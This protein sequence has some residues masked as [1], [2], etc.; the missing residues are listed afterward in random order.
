MRYLPFKPLI[1][2][3][4]L[5]WDEDNN[6]PE[7]QMNSG[8]NVYLDEN[9]TELTVEA[10]VP[11]LDPKNLKVTYHDGMLHIYGSATQK[12]EERKKGKIIKKWEMASSVDYVTSLPRPIDT[13]SIDAKVKN[14]VMIIK[15]KIAEEA[16]P[17]E[18]EVKVG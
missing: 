7:M 16:K 6:W 4:P 11:G 14:G 1:N 15:A 8:L 18:I 10:P 9:E 17:K 3:S 12:D 2:W 13:K 5:M